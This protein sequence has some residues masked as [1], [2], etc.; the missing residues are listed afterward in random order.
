MTVYIKDKKHQAEVVSIDTIPNE[1]GQYTIILELDNEDEKID[2]GEV[3]DVIIPETRVKDTIII[4]TEAIVMDGDDAY[5]FIVDG[6]VAKR[7]PI[8]IDVSQSDV[9]AVK[10]DIAEK[11]EVIVTGQFTL[12]DESEIDIVKEGNDK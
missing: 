7:V 12:T 4:P 5:V 9:S 1:T 6:D 10:G 3:A 11:D 2:L 8:D